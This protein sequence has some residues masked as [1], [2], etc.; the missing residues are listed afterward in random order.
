MLLPRWILARSDW[1]P[2]EPADRYATFPGS[3]TNGTLLPVADRLAFVDQI[4]DPQTGR[5]AE[6]A[7]DIMQ[8]A[9]SDAIV[10]AGHLFEPVPNLYPPRYRAL[11]FP[12]ANMWSNL[13][14]KAVS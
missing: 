2:M 14:T 13:R 10:V 3:G 11:G 4:V 5:A 8:V 7:R 1:P 6:E 12:D 9:W